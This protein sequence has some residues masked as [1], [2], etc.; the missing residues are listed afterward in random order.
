MLYPVVLTL[1]GYLFAVRAGQHPLCENLGACD[2]LGC[3]GPEPTVTAATTIIKQTVTG[4]Q[5]WPTPQGYPGA[6]LSSADVN[7]GVT[8]AIYTVTEPV[9]IAVPTT[10]PRRPD[11]T[12]GGG[13]K[14]VDNSVALPGNSVTLITPQLTALAYNLDDALGFQYP[15]IPVRPLKLYIGAVSN[16]IWAIYRSSGILVT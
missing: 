7:D 10:P 13:W 2:A 1:L 3:G 6:V 11:G 14:I 12:V 5:P 15:D 16:P 9:N 4:S 8:T